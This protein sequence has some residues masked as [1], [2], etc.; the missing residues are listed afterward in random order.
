[1]LAATWAESGQ[2]HTP[3]G[4]RA[5]RCVVTLKGSV[6]QARG[7]TPA[8]NLARHLRG[9]GTR[10]RLD[11]QRFV[12]ET[13][14]RR[15]LRPRVNFWVPMCRAKGSALAVGQEDVAAAGVRRVAARVEQPAYQVVGDI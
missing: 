6:G 11:A 2:R 9:A 15:C 13:R 5:G 14:G 1:M 10:R 7:Q 4:A 8:G 12:A 3:A